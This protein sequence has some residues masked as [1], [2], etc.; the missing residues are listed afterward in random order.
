[1]EMV[2]CS[3]DILL[4]RIDSQAEELGLHRMDVAE[5]AGINYVS[6]INNF[7][8]RK[9]PKFTDLYMI[10]NSIGYPFDDLVSD[11]SYEPASDE[12]NILFWARK[13]NGS[14]VSSSLLFSSPDKVALAKLFSVLSAREDL[15]LEYQIIW[16]I[17]MLCEVDLIFL[18]NHISIDLTGHE[19]R[20]GCEAL[21]PA[22]IKRKLLPAYLSIWEPKY[23]ITHSLWTYVDPAIEN[24][25]TSR[26][27][28]YRRSG[29]STWTFEIF[30]NGTKVGSSPL[31]ETIA[32]VCNILQ[33][34]PVDSLVRAAVPLPSNVSGLPEIIS[35]LRT[36]P[37]LARLLNDIVSLDE[38]EL[39]HINKDLDY[40][41]EFPFSA[42]A[43]IHPKLR[44]EY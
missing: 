34:H 43:Y 21:S 13:E 11:N 24:C 29:V 36:I 28:F 16:K 6:Y 19:I 9:F 2:L 37:G 20:V 18:L 14:L 38:I 40:I 26:T 31:V 30:K 33:L 39:L 3:P 8:K 10:A 4:E 12:N 42:D 35:E 23:R 27:R 44:K 7:K 1:M 41:R 5:Q 17:L 22:A 25:C 15:K 32:K